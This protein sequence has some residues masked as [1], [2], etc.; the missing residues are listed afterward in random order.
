V[1]L[2]HEKETSQVFP[3]K[4]NEIASFGEHGNILTVHVPFLSC[5]ILLFE[6]ETHKQNVEEIHIPSSKL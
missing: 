1:F 2:L 6:G 3:Q 4:R 5:D